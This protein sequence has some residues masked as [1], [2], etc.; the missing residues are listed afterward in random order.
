MRSSPRIEL[1]RT[2]EDAR[3]F[4]LDMETLLP[5]RLLLQATS[6][7]GKSW[8]LRRI[9]EQ[10]HGSIQQIVIDPEG[11]FPS[12]REKYDYVL[13]GKGGDIAAEPRLA[14]MLAHRLLELGVS[15]VCDLYEMRARERPHFVKVF[16]EGLINAPR[17]LWHP[18][19][20]V[21][22]EAHAYCPEKADSES[23]DAVCDLC[24]RGRKRGFCAILAT[25]RLSNLNKQAAAQCF[26]VMVGPTSLDI[27]RKRAVEALG[28]S[29]AEQKRVQNLLM[30]REPGE[31]YCIGRAMS[32]SLALVKVGGV[33]THHPEIARGARAVQGPPP[34]PE[35]V[36]AMLAKLA[37]LPRAAEEDIQERAGLQRRV[38]ELTGELAA[39]KRVAPGRIDDKQELELRAEVRAAKGALAGAEVLHRQRIAEARKAGDE[40][41]G[42]LSRVADLAA[43]A[44]AITLPDPAVSLIEW[45]KAAGGAGGPPIV[46][47]QPPEPSMR[48]L[49]GRRRV[50]GPPPAGLDTAEPLLR[51]GALRMLRTLAQHHPM[52]MTRSQL[53]TL[54]GFTP[55]GETFGTYL[56]DL[57]RGGYIALE[58]REVEITEAG[59]ERA[60][61]VPPTPTTLDERLDVWRG[62]L[63]A[64]ER[65]MLDILVE[66]YPDTLSRQDLAER[67]GFEAS[68]GTF[69]TYLGVLRRNG[70]IE[71]RGPEVRASDTLFMGDGA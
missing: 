61:R 66:V 70:L 36:K 26:N 42:I 57:R 12:L 30:T 50:P 16:L 38:R 55:S 8:A 20:I 15:A 63:R 65:K 32:K 62:A 3:P 34:P 45:D 29:G 19:L 21:V 10:S 13:V 39:A 4:Y 22:D 67:T 52:V 31:F 56:G 40:L 27:D 35:R 59:L 33:Q 41:K 69:G 5:T 44:A 47:T 68:G 71:V 51:A 54:S 23:T 9:L 1:G 43:K 17:K 48:R 11:E 25:Q 53:G 46:G 2:V 7:G 60:G 37:D 58:G 64:G 24:T 28:L 18:V 14:E 6:G 49:D